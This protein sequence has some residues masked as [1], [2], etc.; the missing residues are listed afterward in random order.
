MRTVGRTI[1]AA[2]SDINR[3]SRWLWIVVGTV[4]SVAVLI[5][6]G[7]FWFGEAASPKDGSVRFRDRMSLGVNNLRFYVLSGAET[8]ENGVGVW[9]ERPGGIYAMY[10]QKDAHSILSMRGDEIRQLYDKT[11]RALKKPPIQGNYG[12]GGIVLVGRLP[13]DGRGPN[14][15]FTTI[16]S[17]IKQFVLSENQISIVPRCEFTGPHENG[18]PKL[19]AIYVVAVIGHLPTGAYQAT[20]AIEPTGDVHERWRNVREI[21][22]PSYPPM[23][24]K[25]DVEYHI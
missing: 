21:R 2:V 5:G 3:Q 16:I 9:D 1:G 14:A 4:G 17:G 24:C 18:E 22:L 15:S 6:I 25:F 12:T 11:R 13:G 19:Q 8:D 10:I 7:S 20:I 23:K